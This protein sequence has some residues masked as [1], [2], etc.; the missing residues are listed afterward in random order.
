MAIFQ[1]F[2]Y[3]KW[4]YFNSFSVIKATNSLSYVLRFFSML[5]PFLCRVWPGIIQ[6]FG[7]GLKILCQDPVCI[8]FRIYFRFAG[9]CC[10]FFAGFYGGVFMGPDPNKK[11]SSMALWFGFLFYNNVFYLHKKR[12]IIKSLFFSMVF[13]LFVFLL[14]G[15]ASTFDFFDRISI[16]RS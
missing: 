4:L 8:F 11:E 2:F 7:S 12:A 9:S 1:C 3:N 16:Y 5:L 10:G 6:E 13:H 15:T 14:F